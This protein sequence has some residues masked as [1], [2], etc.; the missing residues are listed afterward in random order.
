MKKRNGMDAIWCL[1][2][3][4]GLFFLWAC[5]PSMDTP[6]SHESKKMEANMNL[7]YQIETDP[8]TIPAIDAAAPAIVETASFGLG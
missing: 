6:A 7:A 8:L 2:L 3:M 4:G 1:F 5:S